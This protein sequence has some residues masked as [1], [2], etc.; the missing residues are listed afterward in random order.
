MCSEQVTDPKEQLPN[1]QDP[2]MVPISNFQPI[3]CTQ[4]FH[5]SK[6]THKHTNKQVELLRIVFCFHTFV[7]THSFRNV[8][9]VNSVN[10]GQWDV[11]RTWSE[12][13]HCLC[14]N[15]WWH[16]RVT[17]HTSRYVVHSQS[18][19][20]YS[21]RSHKLPTILPNPVIKC[22]SCVRWL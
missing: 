9:N 2:V 13:E 20:T 17:M 4:S 11:R 21:A 19:S 16:V 15:G 5:S 6:Q 8:K 3:R 18:C 7:H 10:Y 14:W 1:T 12:R 22:H